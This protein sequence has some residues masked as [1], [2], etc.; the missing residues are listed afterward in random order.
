MGLAGADLDKYVESDFKIR[1]GLCPNGHGLLTAG[2]GFQECPVC[3][4]STN[5]LAELD[6]Q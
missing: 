2:E 4:F 5:V 1:S 3:H 6:R